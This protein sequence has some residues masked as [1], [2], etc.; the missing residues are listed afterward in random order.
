MAVYGRKKI[1]GGEIKLKMKDEDK[2]VNPLAD[3]TGI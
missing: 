1:H 2:D 3:F